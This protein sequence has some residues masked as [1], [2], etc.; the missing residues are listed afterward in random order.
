MPLLDFLVHLLSFIAPAIFLA[1]ALA[2][3]VR[4]R[5]GTDALLLGWWQCLLLNAVLGAL[6]LGLGVALGGHDGRMATYAMLVL[7]MASC[8][9]L[10]AGG[11]RSAARP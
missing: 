2:V 9:W 11:G 5:W 6:V 10:L 1:C 7:V 3:W 8:Q 4:V